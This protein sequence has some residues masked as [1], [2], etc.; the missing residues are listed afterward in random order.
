[1]KGGPGRNW[2]KTSTDMDQQEAMA[3][4]ERGTRNALQSMQSVSG[5]K[6]VLM[7][8][9]LDS[10]LKG[11]GVGVVPCNP[12]SQ[13]KSINLHADTP[14]DILH[15]VLLGPLGDIAEMALK[16]MDPRSRES[17]RAR[18]RSI[19]TDAIV[20]K[21]IDGKAFIDYIG[22]QHGRDFKLLMQLGVFVYCNYTVSSKVSD[23]LIAIAKLGSVVYVRHIDNMDQ[24][25]NTLDRCIDELL[26][27]VAQFNVDLFRKRKF[28]MLRHLPQTVRRFGPLMLVSTEAFESFNKIIRSAAKNS[29]RQSP[30]RDIAAEFASAYQ[31][32]HIIS[33]GYWYCGNHRTNAELCSTCFDH[34]RTQPLYSRVFL[35]KTS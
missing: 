7:Q 4:T 30:S 33:G 32:R 5:T 24:Y 9:G 28:H 3:R 19:S 20:G 8:P 17:C 34:D 12:L 18:F 13:L 16:E 29:N 21:N 35:V 6:D 22:G 2:I 25:C 11:E 14:P 15:T 23:V 1:M 26:A 27:A 10:L 31:F